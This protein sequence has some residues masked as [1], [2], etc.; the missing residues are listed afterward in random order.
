[1][2]VLRI[3]GWTLLGVLALLLVLLC[4]PVRLTFRFS[5]GGAEATLRYAF[6][7][8]PLAGEEKRRRA[9]EKA[10]R[11]ARKEAGRRSKKKKQ[12]ERPRSLGDKLRQA[13]AF[14]PLTG[15]VLHLALRLAGKLLRCI[16]IPHLRVRVQVGGEDPAK[17]AVQYGAIS[18]AAGN[19]L[20]RLEKDGRLGTYSVRICPDLL[21]PAIQAEG[22][23]KL[24]AVPLRVLGAL[25]C[26]LPE[27]LRLLPR[28]AKA[29]E[30]AE[31][32]AAPEQNAA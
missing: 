6:L 18:A 21:A 32:A 31:E 22:E 3:L 16:K 26:L 13:R 1:M 12:E 8:F 11:Q 24:S 14:L 2:L 27:I 10:A 5:P 20:A 19:L 9:E 17:A 30:R 23:G 29:G 15:P 28:L 4:V 7:R 25:V